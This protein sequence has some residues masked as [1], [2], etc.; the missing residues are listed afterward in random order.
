VIPH[1]TL[2]IDSK[3]YGAQ[4]AMRTIANASSA[5]GRT[6]EKRRCTGRGSGWSSRGQTA[7]KCHVVGDKVVGTIEGLHYKEDIWK[8]MSQEQRDKVVELHKAK[9]AG[10]AVKA[11]TMT[12]AGSVPMDVSDQLQ[13]LTRAVQSLDSSIDGGRRSTDRQ[14]SSHRCGERS[15]SRSSSRLHGSHQSREHAGRRTR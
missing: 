1:L 8:A 15:R 3:E 4:A 12:T 13:T 2:S 10:R 14:T 6:P 7:G 5:S 9:S 11:A